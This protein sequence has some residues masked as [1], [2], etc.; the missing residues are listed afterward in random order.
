[1]IKR[2][3][4]YTNILQTLPPKLFHASLTSCCSFTVHSASPHVRLDLLVCSP[5]ESR[6]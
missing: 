4:E 1:M 3:A 2:Q 6:L 5:S